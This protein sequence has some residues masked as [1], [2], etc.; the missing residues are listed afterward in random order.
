[1]S[2]LSQ[3]IVEQ[4]LTPWFCS[5]RRRSL[6]SALDYAATVG[7]ADALD[8]LE[9]GDLSDV[10]DIAT[11]DEFGAYLQKDEDGQWRA[12]DITAGVGSIASDAGGL[13]VD[14]VGGVVTLMTTE[15]FGGYIRIG[16][17]AIMNHYGNLTTSGSGVG[18]VTF[19]ASPYMNTVFGLAGQATGHLTS[20]DNA[21]EGGL[22]E[23]VASNQ[24]VRA[25][26]VATGALSAVPTS[27]LVFIDLLE[28]PLS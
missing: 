22:V 24:L 8:G 6:F 19:D 9:L 17:F 20:K 28:S 7:A 2:S 3:K 4:Y 1:M 26:F 25:H 18:T 12:Q 5:N 15:S 14:S 10:V 27:T 21:V 11:P 16:R 23:A 13:A